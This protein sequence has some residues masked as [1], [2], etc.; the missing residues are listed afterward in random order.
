M[1]MRFDTSPL[2][3]TSTAE[4][5]LQDSPVL[6]RVGVFPYR[7][8]DG[9][10]RYELR[11]PEEVFH[12]ETLA[13]LKGKPIT[14]GHPG[15]VT[16][17]NAKAHT[18]GAVLSEGRQDGEDTRGDVIVHDTT[19]V[20]QGK[21]DLS[22]GYTLDL[23]ET[24]GVWNGQ[25]YDA[26]QRHI[27]Y[28]HLALVRAGRAGNA[29]LNLDAAD[30]DL[31]NDE[32]SN[33]T[34]VKVRLDSGLSY[35]A[36]PEVAQ[37]LE[38]LRAKAAVE[39]KRADTEQARADSEKSRA[40]E[41]AGKIEQ[42]RKDGEAAALARLKLEGDAKT[43]GVELKQD[44]A[45]KDIRVAVI[46]AVRGDAFDVAGKSDAYI[47]VAYDMAVAEKGRRADSIGQQ[48]RDMQP[49]MKQDG[50]DEG[51]GNAGANQSAAA[52]RVRMISNMNGG[53]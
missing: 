10:T 52:A 22:C 4:G 2:K 28:N 5:F 9:S 50:K 19:P 48:R 46:K 18:V 21:K 39:T 6:T 8:A 43:M 29:R 24:P 45:D 44:M 15:L 12:P 20:A 17:R 13:S 38:A 25:R 16:A 34:T 53:Q 7:R 30:A 23:D 36:A 37:E 42:A 1:E 35:D 33:M 27:R 51:G 41:A 14:D 26:V 31:S 40:D 11:P 47:E 32:E 49:S 3:A